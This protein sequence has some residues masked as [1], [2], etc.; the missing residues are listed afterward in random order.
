IDAVAYSGIE[1]TQLHNLYALLYNDIVAEATEE[2]TGH[3]G[4]VWARSTFA[5][6]QRHAA[7]WSGDVNCSFPAMA[8]TLRGGLSMAMCGHAFWSHDVGG[9]TG[10][11]SP[12][13]YARWAQFGL[14][15]PLT[16]A[17]GNSSRLPWDFGP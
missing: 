2:V 15:S 3:S 14:L 6:G 17:H 5:G 12:E 10:H 11:P 1:G 16:R 4:L 13:L 9:F 7:Q 8:A